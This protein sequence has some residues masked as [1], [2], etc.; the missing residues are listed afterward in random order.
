MAKYSDKSEFNRLRAA[1]KQVAKPA[2]KA[3]DVDKAFDN[4]R[5]KQAGPPTNSGKMATPSN[6]VSFLGEQNNYHR[7]QQK[8]EIVLFDKF[9]PQSPKTT[10]SG[11]FKSVNQH[12][13]DTISIGLRADAKPAVFVNDN[14]A[15]AKEGSVGQ[16]RIFKDWQ[17]TVKDTN[18]KLQA[19]AANKQN[20]PAIRAIANFGLKLIKQGHVEPRI[21]NDGGNSTRTSAPGA[22]FDESRAKGPDGKYVPAAYQR[23]APDPNRPVPQGAVIQ[24]DK[25]ARASKSAAASSSKTARSLKATS[26]KTTTRSSQPAA[27]GSARQISPG[28]RTAPQGPRSV[29]ASDKAAKLS[30][31]SSKT[32]AAASSVQLKFGQSTASAKA[33]AAA[34]HSVVSTVSPIPSISKMR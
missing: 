23:G 5:N 6:S 25:K 22:S 12:G 8:G 19:I 4:S 34:A 24:D 3:G 21:S 7:Q 27:K 16:P 2:L 28:S 13:P 20:P 9:E 31:A 1:L 30:S 29:T 17:E 33:P 26:H 10:F 18:R 15:Y 11:A 32:S 14:K